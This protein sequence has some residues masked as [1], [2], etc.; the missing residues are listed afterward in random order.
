[1][2][3][4]VVAGVAI[5]TI[6]SGIGSR[7]PASFSPLIDVS[8]CR[9][10]LR[11]STSIVLA[12]ILAG[13]GTLDECKEVLRVLELVDDAFIIV[14]ICSDIASSHFLPSTCVLVFESNHRPRPSLLR[15]FCVGLLLRFESGVLGSARQ[16]RLENGKVIT[17]TNSTPT[18]AVST[19]AASAIAISSSARWL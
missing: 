17:T 4:L 15:F 5:G 18:I 2:H 10:R 6:F 9:G 19:I 11:P 13:S 14:T 16:C 3:E 8:A 7:S 12:V 1:M